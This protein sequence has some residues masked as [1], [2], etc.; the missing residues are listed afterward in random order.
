VA[1]VLF[2][3][4]LTS[5]IVAFFAEIAFIVLGLTTVSGGSSTF[6]AWVS[7][8]VIWGCIGAGVLCWVIA[9]SL[10]LIDLYKNRP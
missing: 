4:G 2:A 8:L 5:F 7:G 1:K 10:A 6:P 3:V 9:A